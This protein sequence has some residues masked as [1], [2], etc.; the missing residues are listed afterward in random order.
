MTDEMY[1]K[2]VR[3]EFEKGNTELP[4]WTC[5]NEGCENQIYEETGF[6]TT[7]DFSDKSMKVECF[8]CIIKKNYGVSEE[9]LSEAAA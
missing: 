6:A 3:Y 9:D 8:E 5:D 1:L 7:Y 4:L 2:N